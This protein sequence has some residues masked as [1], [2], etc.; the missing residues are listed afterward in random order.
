MIRMTYYLTILIFTQLWVINISFASWQAVINGFRS[1]VQENCISEIKI[2][3]DMESDIYD[4]PPAPPPPDYYCNIVIMPPDFIDPLRRDIRKEGASYY[5]WILCIN[6]KGNLGPPLEK[7]TTLS[8]IPSEFSEGCATIREGYNGKGEMVVSNMS[9][10]SS[11]DVNG[12]DRNQYFLI[13]YWPNKNKQTISVVSSH[14]AIFPS[15]DIEVCHGSNQHFFFQKDQNYKVK[16]IIVDSEPIGPLTGYTLS[17][18][19]SDHTIEVIFELQ[20]QKKY[21]LR[22]VIFLLQM[23]SR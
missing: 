3:V 14:G 9:A 11:L 18:I 5:Q 4:A 6:P 20:S 17:N 23:L 8:W 22:D 7:T 16:N 2:G 13:E 21:D 1:D 19:T 15:G 10:V 12:Q